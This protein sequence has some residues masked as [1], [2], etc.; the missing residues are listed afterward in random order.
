MTTPV[1]KLPELHLKRHVLESYLDYHFSGDQNER[2]AYINEAINHPLGEAV[3]RPHKGDSKKKVAL[4]YHPKS[5]DF[6]LT[7]LEEA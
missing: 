7:D 4:Q 6:T 1:Y 3:V 5:D 2:E